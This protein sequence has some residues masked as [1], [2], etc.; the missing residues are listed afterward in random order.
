MASPALIPAEVS[1][2]GASGYAG[3]ELLRLLSRHPF[4]RITRVIAQAAAG[5]PVAEVHPQFAGQTEA[6]FDAYDLAILSG[7]DV[8]MLALPSGEAMSIVPDLLAAGH[9]VIDLS[10][11][12][13]LRD[14]AAYERYYHRPHTAP[15]LLGSSVYGLPELSAPAIASARLIANPGCYPTSILLPLIPLLRAGLISPAGLTITSLSGVSGAGRSASLELSFTEVNE[16]ARAYKV[17]THQH[18][19]EIEQVLSDHA[20]RS[21]SCTFVP[22]LVPLTRGI[23][24]TITAE[25]TGTT[26]PAEVVNAYRR[27]Y[28]KSPFVRLST[29]RLP[30]LKHVVGSNFID[31][32]FRID[33]DRGRIVILSAIDNLLKGAAGQAVQNLNLMLGF[34][35]TEGLR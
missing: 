30:E 34:S 31:I 17:G 13:R 19:P 24:T 20:G 22:H 3:R 8:V 2:I 35:E 6:V 14:A 23:L 28:E 16:S 10:G 12:F 27:I 21:V 25:L 33:P 9:R 7:S 29:E 15:Q 1:I 26:S 5:K 4:V 11:D 32:G 18:L